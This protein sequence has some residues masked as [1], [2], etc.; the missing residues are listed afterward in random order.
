MVNILV[1]MSTYNGEKYIKDQIMTILFQKKVSTHLLIRDDGSIDNT[2]KIVK[3]LKNVYPDRISIY[4]GNNLGFTYSFY[5]LINKAE[6]YDYYAFADQDDVWAENKLYD[7]ITCMNTKYILY[8]S[9]MD[10]VDE[11][12]TKIDVLY[13]SIAYEK[14]LLINCFPFYNPFGCTIVWKEELQKKV[15]NNL[16]NLRIPH[17]LWLH[18]AASFNGKV[19]IDERKQILHRIHDHNACGIGKNFVVRLKKLKKYYL[20]DYRI[21]TDKTIKIAIEKYGLKN[22]STK[23]ELFLKQI[24]N[25][26]NSFINKIKL[27]NN[28]QFKLIKVEKRL[29]FLFLILVNKF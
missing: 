23:E 8:A 22:F 1:L 18:V 28:K 25:Y 19:Y 11:N 24:L 14:N 5:D 27:F 2:I 13:K 12:L 16:P 3:D 15:R 29:E 10:I 6:G 9:N 21:T 20:S 7:A 17:D 26:K 4:G